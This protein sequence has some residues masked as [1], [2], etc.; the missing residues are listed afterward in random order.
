MRSSV[1]VATARSFSILPSSFSTV[2][3]MLSRREVA[4]VRS[5]FMV[6]IS[7][8]GVSVLLL[9]RFSLFLSLFVSSAGG[10]SFFLNILSTKLVLVLDSL[11]SSFF[12]SSCENVL[13][14]DLM[15]LSLFVSSDSF[16]VF[17]SIVSEGGGVSVSFLFSGKLSP[18]YYMLVI[19]IYI[20]LLCLFIFSIFLCGLLVM[21]CRFLPF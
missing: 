16:F 9:I 3:D 2:I 5:F 21:I 4:P 11:L 7:F 1:P 6:F 8:S 12:I 18:V 15:G 13:S 17:W 20:M 14:S 10:F 19:S